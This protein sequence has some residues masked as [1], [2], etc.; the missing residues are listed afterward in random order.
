MTEVKTD[1]FTQ[2]VRKSYRNLCQYEKV[3]KTYPD[4]FK[5]T[6][7]RKTTCVWCTG[8]E[9]TLDDIMTTKDHY[10]RYQIERKIT[11]I[12]P[13]NMTPCI[14][15]K[16]LAELK[17]INKFVIVGLSTP[18]PHLV[19]NN[20]GHENNMF[21]TFCLSRQNALDLCQ[22]IKAQ[23]PDYLYLAIDLKKRVIIEG[24]ITDEKESDLMVDILVDM[25]K[26]GKYQTEVAKQEWF[27]PFNSLIDDDLVEMTVEDLDH[28]RRNLY[29]VLLGLMNKLLVNRV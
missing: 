13:I 11:G 12:N 2:A 19:L 28:K 23:Y 7:C 15:G 4:E 6:F 14:Y 29:E 26:E 3:R 18:Q 21:V 24:G 22:I 17:E 16:K 8:K 27:K 10:C 1:L 20:E 25:M 9:L 5:E